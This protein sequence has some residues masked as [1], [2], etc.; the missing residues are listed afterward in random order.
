MYK[1]PAAPRLNKT[2]AV[3]L[4]FLSLNHGQKRKASEIFDNGLLTRVLVNPSK[5]TD[6]TCIIT[7]ERSSVNLQLMVKIKKQVTKKPF[8]VLTFFHRE[9]MKMNSKYFV[10]GK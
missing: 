10:L 5:Y 8:F 3:D 9:K 4:L 2:M 1:C 7:G 6:T